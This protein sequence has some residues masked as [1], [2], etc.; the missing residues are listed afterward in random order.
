MRSTHEKGAKVEVN[1][2]RK[3]GAEGELT[4]APSLLIMIGKSL[5]CYYTLII[6]SVPLSIGW[7]LVALGHAA[8]HLHRVTDWKILNRAGLAARR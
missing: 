3:G 7:W 6:I 1:E 4:R 2:N 5:N 8:I